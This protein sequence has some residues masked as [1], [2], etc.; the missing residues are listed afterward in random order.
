MHSVENQQYKGKSKGLEMT[1]W[2]G[3]CGCMLTYST[4][5]VRY[6]FANRFSDVL[7]SGKQ[8]SRKANCMK[9][10]LTRKG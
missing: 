8:A 5:L 1:E 9:I 7:F 3:G 10:H 2:H 6:I 4:K